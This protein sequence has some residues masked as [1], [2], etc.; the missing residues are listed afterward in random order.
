M[1]ASENKW[2]KWDGTIFGSSVLF[3]IVNLVAYE[4]IVYLNTGRARNLHHLFFLNIISL[5]MGKRILINEIGNRIIRPDTKNKTIFSVNCISFS[6]GSLQP[7]DLPWCKVLT[8]K[9]PWS[10]DCNSNYGLVNRLSKKTLCSFGWKL[11]TR[12]RT[13][14]SLS[15]NT[16]WDRMFSWVPLVRLPP[17]ISNSYS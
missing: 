12:R 8:A 4:P 6:I 14:F 10:F 13:T 7:L 3:C 17:R 2:K 9:I 11:L 16:Y 15:S 5:C 1:R